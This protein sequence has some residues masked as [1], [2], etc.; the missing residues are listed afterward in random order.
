MN[1]L[2]DAE[3]TDEGVSVNLV[4]SHIWKSQ[5]LKQYSTLTCH[6]QRTEV[7]DTKITLTNQRRRE[8]H[9]NGKFPQEHAQ[10][11]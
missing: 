8:N 11:N 5:A 4:K 6:P 7:S 9:P 3:V 2:R 1:Q 10:A